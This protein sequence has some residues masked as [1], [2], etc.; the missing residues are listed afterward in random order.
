MSTTGRFETA[1]NYYCTLPKYDLSSGIGSILETFEVFCE[2]IEAKEGAK[3]QVFLNSLPESVK[4]DM[5][6]DDIFC[7]ACHTMS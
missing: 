1:L 4:F 6:D 7:T 3:K 2:G 5:Q